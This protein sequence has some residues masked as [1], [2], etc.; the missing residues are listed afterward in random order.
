MALTL[1]AVANDPNR[2]LPAR[3]DDN[4]DGTA[5]YARWFKYPTSASQLRS[6]I[7]TVFGYRTSRGHLADNTRAR[8]MRSAMCP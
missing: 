1:P 5:G 4:V 3:V 2:R 6:N 8:R 7:E